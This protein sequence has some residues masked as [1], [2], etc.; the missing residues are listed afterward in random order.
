M[1]QPTTMPDDRKQF[2]E[3][4][5]KGFKPWDSGVPEP[6]LI[7]LLE[8]GKLPG[9]TVLEIGC[10]TGT[11]AIELARRGY[12]VTAIDFVQQAIE[13]AK[14]KAV[15]AGVAIDFRLGDA[16]S[17]PLGGPYDVLFDRGVYHHLR[18]ANLS[19]FQGMLKRVTRPGTLWFSLA[20]NSKEKRV[21]EGPPTVSEDE[22]RAEL[23]PLFDILELHEVRFGTNQ[24]GFRPL[25]WAILMKRK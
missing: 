19:A 25:A 5:A 22:I 3:F 12:Q 8:A 21:N 16:T 1:P 18:M 7:R 20:G 9:K 11:N 2:E 15:S 4:Y 13:T 24:E 23:G 6:E 14:Q 17:M 10:G